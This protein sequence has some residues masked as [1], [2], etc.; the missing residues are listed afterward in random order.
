V[1]PVAGPAPH[2]GPAASRGLTYE[3]ALAVL[4]A[5]GASYQ[6]LQTWGEEGEWKFSCSIPN[7][8]NPHIRRSYEA[9]APD[10]VLAM[11]LV[12]DKIEREGR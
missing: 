12:L 9:R 10:P 4:K 7:R 3:Q 2:Y 1:T 11:R 5:K 8:Q 6:C